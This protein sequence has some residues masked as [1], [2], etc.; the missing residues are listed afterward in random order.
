MGNLAGLKFITRKGNQYFYDDNTGM[1]FPCPDAM[2]EILQLYQDRSKAE[3]IDMLGSK[4]PKRD[5]LNYFDLIETWSNTHGSFFLEKRDSTFLQKVSEEKIIDHLQNFGFK[6]MILNVTENCNLRCKYCLFSSEYL[7]ERT[8]SNNK[9]DFSIAKKAID[10]YHEWCQKVKARIPSR[11]PVITF[12]GGEPLLAFALVRRVIEYAK[13]IFEGD[14]FFTMTTNAVLLTEQIIDYVVENKVS[15]SISLDGSREEHDRLRVAKNGDGTFAKVMKNLELLWKKYPHYVYNIVVS[16]HDYGT[17]LIAVKR[18][19]EEKKDVLPFVARASFVNPNF[20]NYL[21]RYDEKDRLAFKEQFRSLR[22]EYF[23][24]IIKKN[25]H[26]PGFL[27]T[28]VGMN[29][30]MILLKQ[31]IGDHRHLLLPYT[32]ACVPGDKLSVSWDGI[33]HICEKINGNFPIG[34][35]EQGLDFSKIKELICHYRETILLDCIQCPITR[36]C[37]SCYSQFAG[38]GEFKREPADVCEPRI[39]TTK[40]ELA[41]TYSILEE[42]PDA[43]KTVMTDYYKELSWI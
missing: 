23:H 36:L 13:S 17:D 11:T 42:N 30:R 19:F 31:M 5:I 2:F 35:V 7:Y 18:F 4:Y 12:Y 38:E 15:V 8:H 1:V 32:W 14:V 9:M 33:L 34:T 24:K 39:L 25:K 29:C 21:D 41:F 10:Y 37:M 20:T 27:D 26:I 16:T 40:E 6:Q 22:K 43:F 28:L 3:I